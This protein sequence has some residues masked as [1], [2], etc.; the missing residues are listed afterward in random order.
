MPGL[1]GSELWDS[2]H[3]KYPGMRVLFTSGYDAGLLED[4]GALSQD[5]P[6]IRKPFTVEELRSRVDEVLS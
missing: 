1:N 5:L 6:M 2:L 4:R 3:A